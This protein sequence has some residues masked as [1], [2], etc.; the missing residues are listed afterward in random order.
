MLDKFF[1]CRERG[2]QVRTEFLAGATTFA[3]MAYILFLNP[4]IL[5]DAGMNKPAVLIA[6]AIAAGFGSILMGLVSNLPFALAPGM[7]MNAYFAYAVVIQMGIPWRT[8]LAAVF[9]DGCIFCLISVLPLREKMIRDIPYNIKLAIASAIG[10]FISLIG[11]KNVKIVVANPDTLVTLGRVTDPPVML[12]LFGIILA[13][14]LLNRRIK[15]G[16]IL[17]VLA[18]TAIGLAVPDGEGGRVT[19]W[20]PLSQWDWPSWELFRQGAFQLDFQGAS[21]LGLAMIVFTFTFVS[22]FDTA[23]TFVGLGTKLGWIDAEHQTFPGANR[24]L[25][26]ESFAIMV[27]ALAGTS[28]TSTYIESAAGIAEGGRTGLTAVVT[29]CFFLCSLVL[30]PLATMIPSQATSPILILVGFLMMESVL[31]IDLSD[32]TEALPA[33]LTLIMVPFTFNVA[34]GLVFGILSYVLLKLL[35]GRYRE[36]GATMWVLSFLSCLSL[37]RPHG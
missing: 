16:L 34:N 17:A 6:T 28:T 10:L 4:D 37:L 14:V 20:L 11:L 12:A 15:G 9:L 5:G 18:I 8:A 3:T 24:G 22:I 29:G 25:L 36:I 13:A 30:A 19:H 2:S 35:T 27:G 7:G 32:I 31:K 26:A 23:G 33:F 21:Q 1:H